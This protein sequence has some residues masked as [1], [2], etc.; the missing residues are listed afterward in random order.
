MIG[1]IWNF[2]K[3]PKVPKYKGGIIFFNAAFECLF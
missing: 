1:T 3:I 2:K